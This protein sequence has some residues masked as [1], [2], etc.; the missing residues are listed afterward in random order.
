MSETRARWLGRISA[1][2]P[3]AL[4]LALLAALGI[5]FLA[6]RLHTAFSNPTEPQSVQIG[7]LV[8]EEIGRNRYVAVSGT[9]VYSIGYEETENGRLVATLYALIDASTGDLVFVRSTQP[10]PAAEQ[11]EIAITGMTRSAGSDLRTT[12]ESDLPLFSQA[13]LAA[14]PSLYV[15]AGEAPGRASSLILMIAGLGLVV[16]LCL[17]TLLLCPATVFRPCPVEPGATPSTGE[18]TAKATGRFQRLKQLQPSP[19]AGRG[20]RRFREANANLVALESQRLMVLIH[21]V[22]GYG[23]VGIPLFRRGSDWAVLLEPSHTLELVPGKL[24]AWRERWA[25]RLLHKPGEQKPQTLILSFDSAGAISEV[26]SSLQQMGFSV[27][28]GAPTSL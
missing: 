23:V 21:Y 8:R 7:Q 24:Y 4:L 15:A 14:N 18:P 25:F 28:T 20:T 1:F 26:F 5:W 16:I 22:E 27:G 6:A 13:G 10:A 3:W 11:E 17:A 19:V 2:R 9:A 12:I